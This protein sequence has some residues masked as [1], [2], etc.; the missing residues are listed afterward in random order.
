AAEDDDAAAEARAEI[1]SALLDDLGDDDDDNSPTTP[2]KTLGA[3]WSSAI[4]LAV[5]LI[6]IGLYLALGHPAALAPHDDA[7]NVATPKGVPN[8]AAMVAQL[9]RKLA[10]DPDN[11]EHW[12]MATRTYMTLG[13]FDQAENAYRNLHRLRGDS[14]DLLVGWSQAASRASGAF[15][16]ETATRI[17]RALILDPDHHGALWLAALAAE[18]RAEP[19][20]ALTHLHRL[21]P[22]VAN[23]PQ[24]ADAVRAFI[25][26]LD[27]AGE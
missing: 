9:E 19:D 14:A 5:P 24:A 7:A 13:A 12:A 25:A 16:T 18:S 3:V 11:A 22:R 20:R 27:A 1:E 17:E 21:L 8:V 26:R 2:P 15:S 6:G 10:D 4:A 23:N